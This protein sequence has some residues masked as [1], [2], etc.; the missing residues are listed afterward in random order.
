[1]DSLEH[2]LRSLCALVDL[3]RIRIL[4]LIAD[5]GRTA[6]EIAAGLG[7]DANA[8]AAHLTVL[9]QAGLVSTERSGH[10]R[11]M[12]IHADRLGGIQAVCRARLAEHPAKGPDESI[13]AG[14]RQFFRGGQLTAFPAKHSRYLDVLRVLVEDFEPAIDY[15]EAEVNS[16]LLRRH[17]DFATLRRDLV[18]SGFM[19]RANG[20]YR[21]VR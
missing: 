15:P 13:P 21:R 8:V 1:M 6:A 17:E 9:G 14:V 5:R 11:R 4:A 2:E 3:E 10:E 18:D 16:I 12:R 19:T 20:I 7:L